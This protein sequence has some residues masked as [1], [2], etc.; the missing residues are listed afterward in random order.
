MRPGAPAGTMPAMINLDHAASTPVRP[1]ARA[2]LVR[3]LDAD[4]GNASSS[5]HLGRI[6]REAVEAARD[7]VAAAVG[8]TPADVV[9]TS[10]GTESDNLAIKGLA[11]AAA[12]RPIATRSGRLASRA[13]TCA[14]MAPTSPGGARR[15]DAPAEMTSATPGES[16]ATTGSPDAC[17]S[18]QVPPHPSVVDGYRNTS[19]LA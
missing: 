7:E 16:V 12:A 3:V 17:A 14:A 18:R 6:A 19:A 8:A 13:A 4:P 5:H 9:F 11:W 2:A 15:P 1:A 10:G